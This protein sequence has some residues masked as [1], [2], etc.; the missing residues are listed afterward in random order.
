M[1]SKTTSEMGTLLAVN[2]DGNDRL[3]QYRQRI[4][5]RLAAL[6]SLGRCLA[7]LLFCLAAGVVWFQFQLELSRS[8][9]GVS[10]AEAGLAPVF[11]DKAGSYADE[12][13]EALAA[14]AATAAA[15]APQIAGTLDVQPAGRARPPT[16][17][18][19]R[20][21]LVPPSN[22]TEGR[23]D[24]A[25]HITLLIT[26]RGERFIPMQRYFFDS[27][28]RQKHV[29]LVLIQHGE[30]CLDVDELTGGADN[31]RVSTLGRSSLF[32]LL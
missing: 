28:R 9:R 20:D 14:A 29:D 1:Q 3:P 10:T 4:S 24:D 22:T 13:S 27:I 12:A 17:G 15:A 32:C 21:R 8:W 25:Q 16:E 30:H 31:I 7:A 11:G 18:E 19:W 5:N 6:P 26:F 23:L 2:A